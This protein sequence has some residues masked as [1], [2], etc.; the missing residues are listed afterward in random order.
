[1][2]TNAPDAPPV[3]P[4]APAVRVVPEG[5]TPSKVLTRVVI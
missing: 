3:L 4:P 5:V 2:S 1:M